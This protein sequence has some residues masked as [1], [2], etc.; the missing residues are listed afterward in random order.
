MNPDFTK[1]EMVV[2]YLEDGLETIRL[3]FE[4]EDKV[5]YEAVRMLFQ[6]YHTE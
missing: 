2:K 3:V 6:K 4:T 1:P 5:I